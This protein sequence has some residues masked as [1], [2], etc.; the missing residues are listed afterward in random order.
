[1]A[2]AAGL[3]AG[4][5]AGALDIASS[6]NEA[7]ATSM[8]KAAPNNAHRIAFRTIRFLLGRGS[9]PVDRA[10]LRLEQSHDAALP[11]QL[12][13]GGLRVRRV[14]QSRLEHRYGVLVAAELVQGLGP[15]E[16]EACAGA[17]LLQSLVRDRDGALVAIRL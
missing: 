3:A 5:P 2:L 10:L 1:M 6:A 12:L 8:L 7:P 14:V 4:L 9:E 15:A 11:P 13:P 17:V 16:M